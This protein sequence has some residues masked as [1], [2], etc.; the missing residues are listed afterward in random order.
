[1]LLMM[2]DLCDCVLSSS[3]FLCLSSPFHQIN[4]IIN[5]INKRYT[6]AEI[7]DF[8]KDVTKHKTWK[9]T[10]INVPKPIMKG[11]AHALEYLWDPSI[12][13]EE[14][15]LMSIDTV[16]KPDVKPIRE[17]EK[18][19]FFFFLF[20]GSNIFPRIHFFEHSLS[21]IRYSSFGLKI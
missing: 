5:I 1:L 20:W 6:R 10:V 16:I 18:H 13:H 3:L 17:R 8:V 9:D 4:I 7:V 14:V 21:C 15:E 19:V 11:F 2:I 12:T